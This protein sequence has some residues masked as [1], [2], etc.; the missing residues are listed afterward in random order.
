MSCGF[1]LHPSGAQRP[2]AGLRRRLTKDKLA[3][4]DRE[5]VRTICDHFD[6]KATLTGG[7][8]LLLV[9]IAP[10]LSDAQ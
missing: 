7:H 5:E 6:R 8:F 2:Q 3:K 10:S 4:N 1:G 9:V